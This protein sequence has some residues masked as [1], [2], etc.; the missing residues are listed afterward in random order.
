[1]DIGTIDQIVPVLLEGGFARNEGETVVFN[2]ADIGIEKVLGTGRV[3]HKFTISAPA[4]SGQA[5]AKIEARGGQALV[6]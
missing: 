2:V 4:F 6:V 5:K 1:M 3:T